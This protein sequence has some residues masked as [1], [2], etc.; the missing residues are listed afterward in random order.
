MKH[1]LSILVACA[2]A[3]VACAQQSLEQIVQRAVSEHPKVKAAQALVEGERAGRTEALAPFRPMASANGYFAGGNGSMIFPSTVEPVNYAFL[4]PDGVAAGNLMLMWR[5]WS[6]GRDASARRMGNARVRAAEETLAT[7]RQD[8]ELAVR[9]AYAEFVYRSG[10]VEASKA[11]ATAALE[12]ER[13]T[14]ELEANGKA[15]RAFVLRLSAAARKAEQEVAMAEAAAKMAKAEL[16]EAAGGP[17]EVADGQG[18]A[19]AA[20]RNLVE[21]LAA[22]ARR[23]ELAFMVAMAESM[24]FEAESV[25]R[26]LLPEVSLVAM[27]GTVQTSRGDSMTDSKFGLV[28]SIPLT[29][30]G[31]RSSRASMLRSK[32]KEFMAQVEEMR[33]T[34]KKEIEAAWAEWSAASAVSA[35]AHAGHAAAT[36]AYEVEK[37]RYENGRSTVSELLD[38]LA[39]LARAR[40]DVLESVRFQAQS[41]AKLARASAWD[42]APN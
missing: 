27:G 17:V 13:I 22:G 10:A 35:A 16:E 37:L 18:A 21:A 8:V 6:G 28:V 2:L 29:D 19:Q 14:R 34:V 20:P 32:E 40:L 3:A 11:D 9:L 39:A 31:M 12:M 41:A 5:V 7:V 30:G 26:S 1:T 15:P 25:R 36:E 4:P 23:H 24:G 42:G 33:L 38:S